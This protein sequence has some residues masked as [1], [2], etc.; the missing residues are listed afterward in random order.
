MLEQIVR[1][2]TQKDVKKLTAQKPDEDF[3]PYVCHYDPN[4]ILT[5]NGELLQI[6]R[7]TGLSSQDPE[8]NIISLRDAL[9]DAI[10]DNVKDNHFAFWFHTIRRKKNINPEGF[11]QDYISSLVSH[12]YDEYYDWQH[13]FV[14]ELYITIISE[15]LESSISDFK[16]FIKTFSY[17]NIQQ[18]HRNHLQASH[19]K[20][21]QLSEKILAD[22]EGYGAKILGIKD[23]QGVLYSEPM[24]FF[25]KIVNLH[26]DRYPLSVNDISNDLANYKIAFGDREIEVSGNGNKNF[27]TVLTIKEYHEVSTQSLDKILQLPFEFIITQSFDFFF[28]KKDLQDHLFQN[29][30]LTISNDDYFKQVSGMDNF[31]ES[32]TQSATDYGK[33]QNSI[34]IIAGNRKDLEKDIGLIVEKFNSLGFVLVREDIFLEHCFWAQLPG[35]FSFL[36]RQKI[37]KTLRIAGFAALHS[38]PLG[39]FAANHWGQ[40]V[41]TLRTVLQTPYFFNFHNEDCGHTLIFGPKSSGKTLITNFLLLMARKFHNQIFYFDYKKSAKCFV[42]SLSGKYYKLT[43]DIEDEN[44]LELN[45]LLLE[46]KE[47]NVIFLEKWLR[48]LVLFLKGDISPE[49][50]ASAKNIIREVL[51]SKPESFLNLFDALNNKNTKNIYEKLKIWGSGKLGYVFGS[52]DEINFRD[53]IIGFDFDEV[54]EKKPIVIPTIFYILHKIEQSLDG[55]PAIIV[56]ERTREYLENQIFAQELDSILKRLQEKNCMVIFNIQDGQSLEKS[57]IVPIIMKNVAT[58]LYAGN[59]NAEEFYQNIFKLSADEFE[60]IKLLEQKSHDYLLKHANNS[61]IIDF[62]LSFLEDLTS[63]FS[64]DEIAIAALEEILKTN[65][66]ID[67]E[68]WIVEV[69][70]IVKQFKEQQREEFVAEQKKQIEEERQRRLKEEILTVENKESQEDQQNE[71]E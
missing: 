17:K 41:A 18:N 21:S 43:S 32:D 54:I 55:N 71:E 63:I 37:I 42:K 36:R 14:N 46:N 59:K 49:E 45:P 20:L 27:A 29:R 4:T 15:G 35:N 6:I 7:I 25:G 44:C 68:D 60:I 53:K 34:M 50:F 26:E 48:Q 56:F 64:G 13:N 33:L 69:S 39:N 28:N 11:Y 47:E 51:Q 12:K 5:K 65:K 70:D 19:Q 61:L 3:L 40:A 52:K 1:K 57:A 16:G 38:F 67:V 22:I 66:D 9:R 62:D 10:Y 23:W 24:R 31:M 8:S 58:E 30:V 2:F